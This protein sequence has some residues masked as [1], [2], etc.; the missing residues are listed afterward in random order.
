MRLKHIQEEIDQQWVFTLPK[1]KKSI[2]ETIVQMRETPDG[3][4][5]LGMP[6][7]VFQDNGLQFKGYV[8]WLGNASI[9]IAT[10]KSSKKRKMKTVVHK[11][12]S[13][14]AGLEI[15]STYTLIACLLYVYI[16]S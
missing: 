9:P 6:V 16:L 13:L 3:R 4:L 15:V 8:R 11:S 12:E 7:V 5:K 1:V 2:P 14:V 10:Q